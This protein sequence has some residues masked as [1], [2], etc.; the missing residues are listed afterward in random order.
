MLQ[1]RQS[2]RICL[3]SL[4]YKPF[5]S[6]GLTIYAED[7]ANGL[8]QSGHKVT[9]IAA[10]RAGL[11]TCHW[12]DG[13]EIQRV[14]IDSLDW[15]TYSWRA[16][17]LLND[18]QQQSPFDVVHFLDIHFAYVYQ[19]SFVGSLW[20]SFHQRLTAWAGWPYHTGLTD[21]LRREIYYRIAQAYME[22]RSLARAVRLIASCQSTRAEF[23]NFY[24]VPQERIDQAVQGI[25]TNLFQSRPSAYLRT[26]LGLTNCYVLFFMGFITPRKGMDYLAQAMHLLPPNVHLIIA[27]KWT[28]ACRTR[29]FKILGPAANRVHEVGF[30]SDQERAVYY[31]MTDV[32]VSPS[33]LEGLGLTPIEALACE[34]PAVV[35]SASS[36]AEEVGEA[37][38]V[39]PPFDPPA[40]AL[41][42]QELLA[43][44]DLRRKLGRRGREYVCERFS[45]QQMTNLTVR[46]Y[47]KVMGIEPG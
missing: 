17:Q 4:D 26:R 32:Y 23:V 28:P 11:P 42:I 15:I 35:T 1:S 14:P 36:G 47:E 30:I 45:Y 29:F 39:V 12:L 8:T 25:N 33:F 7:L 3:V 46:S 2:R 34:T 44:D 6:S 43:N 40:M 9:V 19:G 18:L 31:S 10:Q 20:Q 41:A 37:G 13:V 24:G 22:K 21:L 27:G 5:R 16:T 38:I